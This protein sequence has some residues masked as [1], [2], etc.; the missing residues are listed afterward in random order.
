[1]NNDALHRQTTPVDT[2]QVTPHVIETSRLILRKPRVDD[3]Y[4]I[5]SAYARDQ[6]VTRYLTWKPHSSVEETQEFV[7]RALDAW[8][9]EEALTWIITLRESAEVI[10]SIDLRLES[11]ANLGYVLAKPHWNRGY[12]TE[13]VRSVV[14]WAVAQDAVDRV[15]AVCDVENLASARV[16]EKAGLLREGILH[17]W[18]VL[19]N[20][21]IEPRDCY[22]Y[23]RPK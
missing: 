18:I 19:P 21:S 8:E 6:D 15:W 7:H 20:R 2:V 23:A 14:D 9:K 22:C 16:L 17:H 10:G 13:A 5:F 1:M 3:A 4:L 11:N 12:M